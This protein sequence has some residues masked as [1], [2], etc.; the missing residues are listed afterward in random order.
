MIFLCAHALL[1]CLL[2]SPESGLVRCPVKRVTNLAGKPKGDHSL[3]LQCYEGKQL[4]PISNISLKPLWT[5]LYWLKPNSC[6]DCITGG[7]CCK[8]SISYTDAVQRKLNQSTYKNT[9]LSESQ[10]TMNEWDPKV[11][12]RQNSGTWGLPK[13]SNSHGNGR[14]IVLARSPIS[15]YMGCEYHPPTMGKQEGIRFYSSF[16]KSRLASISGL[17]K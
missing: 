13:G 11:A 7:H 3:S 4:T 9:V 12:R 16:N 2:L 14:F 15:N 17:D 10:E 6:T 1:F 8:G 5:N